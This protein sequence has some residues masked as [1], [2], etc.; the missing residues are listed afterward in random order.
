MSGGGAD[1]NS[2]CSHF[3]VTSN[4]LMWKAVGAFH[5]FLNGSSYYVWIYQVQIFG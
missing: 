4:P 2:F 1:S 3:A 5:D